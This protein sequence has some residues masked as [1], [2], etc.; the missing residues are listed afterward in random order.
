MA[1][2]LNNIIGTPF[3]T[4]VGQLIEKATNSASE[5]W[6]LYM[7]IC[8]RINST[9]EGPRDAIKAFKKQLATTT[10]NM[11]VFLTT[12]TVLETCVKNCGHRFHMQLAQKDFLHE[13]TTILIQKAT[14][15]VDCVDRVLGLLQT[16]ADAFQSDP[17]LKEVEVTCKELK[18]KGFEFPVEDV[19][20]APPIHTPARK[21]RPP[22]KL[23]S[24]PT[25]TATLPT[26]PST[27]PSVIVTS[28]ST[29]Q[30]PTLPSTTTTSTTTSNTALNQQPAQPSMNH[31]PAP[32]IPPSIAT[33]QMDKLR[34]ELQVVLQNC[35][36][37][38]ELL[39]ENS[40]G[41][42]NEE[43]WLLMKDL[44]YTSNE[45]HKRLVQLV[46]NYTIEELTGLIL[47]VNDEVTN[48]CLRFD[49]YQRVRK[50][51][52]EKKGRPVSADTS[53]ANPPIAAGSAVVVGVTAAG[54]MY[55]AAVS[56]PAADT[57]A[58]GFGNDDE[59]IEI[60][61]DSIHLDFKADSNSK[62]SPDTFNPFADPSMDSDNK[63]KEVEMS[64]VTG[65]FHNNTS[66][67]TFDSYT[68]QE[69]SAECNEAKDDKEQATSQDFENFLASYTSTQEPTNHDINQSSTNH[70]INQSSINNDNDTH[71]ERDD[72]NRAL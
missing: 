39:T 27:D 23:S 55:P 3:T 53:S 36:I 35:K 11:P 19:E 52:L 49:R 45:C 10:A 58:A 4:P 13:F 50:G 6:A 12:L 34:A 56:T 2:F 28:L 26:N 43:D 30:T 22:T 33:A 62:R 66:S 68:N 40:P 9:E 17:S 29:T 59:L 24:I 67:S 15:P 44:A 72:L 54:G 46:A 37:F 41:Q 14:P 42:E 18:V 60:T 5:N 16:W 71:D 61:A 20:H 47:P 25:I 64:K 69:L 32:I 1:S 48:M 7:E 65:D 57:K 8:D 70:D 63:P 31:T 21:S 38:S 51:V